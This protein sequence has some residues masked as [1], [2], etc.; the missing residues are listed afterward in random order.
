MTAGSSRVDVLSSPQEWLTLRSAWN[1]ILALHSSGINDMDVTASF[2]WTMALWET[3]WSSGGMEVLVLREGAEIAGILPMHR[4]RKTIRHIPCRTIAPLTELYCGRT[5]FLLRL[6]SLANLEALFAHIQGRGWDVLSLTLVQGSVYEV[7]FRKWAAEAGL[8]VQILARTR[9]PYFPLQANWEE[10]FASL[11]KKL[12]STIRNGEKRLR[13]RGEVTYRE[14]RSVEDAIAFNAAALEIERDSWKE[15]AG[16]SIAA[17]PVHEAFH[18]RLT[19]RAAESGFFSG[20]ILFINA[21][22]IAYVMGLLYNG[23]FLDLKESYRNTFREMS[24]GHVLKNFAFTRLYEQQTTVYDFMGACE[25][26]KMKW[27]DKTYVRVTYLLFNNT[28]RAQAARWLS[29][30]AGTK[31]KDEEPELPDVETPVAGKTP[32]HQTKTPDDSK[33]ENQVNGAVQV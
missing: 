22:P 20:H 33:E 30:L 1:E 15:A 16:T 26:Y 32:A 23:V 9:S 5:G 29:S 13:E 8:R 11:P 27:T 18:T 21:Q 2:D 4:F 31:K 7:L 28:L 14:Y 10:H 12:R 24:P 19:I 25:E 6:P 17:N 3:H